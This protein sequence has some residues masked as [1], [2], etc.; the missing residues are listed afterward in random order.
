MSKPGDLAPSLQARP[1]CSPS[2]LEA[3]VSGCPRDQTALRKE[4]T[5]PTNLSSDLHMCL[6]H[7]MHT[8]RHQCIIY[9]YYICFYYPTLTHTLGKTLARSLRW[10]LNQPALPLALILESIDRMKL[11]VLK[12]PTRRPTALLCLMGVQLS[13]CR[14]PGLPCPR[15]RTE[16]TELACTSR[17]LVTK[18]EAFILLFKTQVQSSL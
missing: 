15:E 10:I 4:Q 14:R 6:T 1:I 11:Q 3:E 13:A 16:Q 18:Y 2:T 8:H 7:I 5:P 17:C 12:C 9:L